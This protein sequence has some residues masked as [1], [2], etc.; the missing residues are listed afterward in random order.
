VIGEKPEDNKNAQPSAKP[1]FGQKA[2]FDLGFKIA[3]WSENLAEELRLLEGGPH[4]PVITEVTPGSPAGN[5]GFRPGDMILDVNRQNIQKASDVIRDLK[6][7][8]NIL[9]LLRGNL[10][11]IVSIGR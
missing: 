5:A 11:I 6:Q 1:Y 2:P 4:N 9:R 3:D 7:G 10:M 8:R